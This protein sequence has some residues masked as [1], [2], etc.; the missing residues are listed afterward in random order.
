MKPIIDP[1]A[2]LTF[3]DY[4]SLRATIK[5]VAEHFGY[6][7][8]REPLDLPRPQTAQYSVVASSAA[9]AKEQINKVLP[10]TN[11]ESETARREILI[12]P[13]MLKL[14]PIVKPQLSIEYS[15][16]VSNQLKGTVDYYLESKSSQ[17]LIVE[18]KLADIDRGF[19]QLIAEMVAFHQISELPERP[20]YGAV[21]TGQLWHFG[22][23]DSVAKRIYY[24]LNFYTEPKDIEALLGILVGIL[25]R[26][27]HELPFHGS[28]VS[29]AN[30]STAPTNPPSAASP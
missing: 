10:F 23:L 2:A 14:I 29:S 15:L 13:V 6:E 25:S 4:Y 20:I 8:H 5:E 24:D 26:T 11:L 12:S 9:E 3:S 22:L 19:K 18:A 7:L 28:S 17:V 21:T 30:Q 16:F 1:T 27:S